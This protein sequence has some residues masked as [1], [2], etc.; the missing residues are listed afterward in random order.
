MISRYTFGGVLNCRAN[1]ALSTEEK[2]A[3]NSTEVVL[4]ESEHILCNVYKDGLHFV[5]DIDGGNSG[6][7][8]ARTNIL[9]APGVYI[10]IPRLSNMHW[11]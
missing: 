8:R 3:V 11:Y 9:L 7:A 10:P 2:F 6:G 4:I 1:S 5:S